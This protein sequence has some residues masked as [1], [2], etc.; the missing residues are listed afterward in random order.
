MIWFCHMKTTFDLDD[1]LLRKAKQR[2]AA[3]GIPLR[4]YIEDALRAR[5]LPSARRRGKFTLELPVVEGHRP[6]A[7]DIADR[8][9]LYDLMERE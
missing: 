6:P 5:L 1:E 9:A 8:N 2:A 3:E 4:A 7:V